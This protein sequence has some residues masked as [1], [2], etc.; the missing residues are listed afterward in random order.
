MKPITI[1]GIILIVLGI[2]VG[3]IVYYENYIKPNSKANE[4]LIEGKLIFERGDKDSVNTAINIFTKVIAK[5][6]KSKAVTDA[7][8]YIGRCYEKL[9]LNRL[10][11]LKYNYIIKNN[12]GNL[13]KEF[14]KEILV[15]LAHINILKQYSEEGINQLF[16][17]LNQSFNRE[18]RSRVY[19][20]LGHTYLKLGEYKRSKR[21]FDISLTENGSNEDAILGK[22]RANKRMGYDNETYDLYDHFLKYYGAISQYTK[23][24][25]RSYKEQAYK[26]G[27]NAFRRG[28]YNN[29]I[30][31]F[32]RVLRNFPYDK[33]S[34]NSLY[35]TGESYFALRK[36]DTSID[37]FNRVLT[38]S[39]YHKDQDAQIKKGY[40]YFM[41]KKFD[42]AA[43][44]F[45][46]YLRNYPSGK[47][48]K[49]AR[50]WK[51]MSTKELLYRIKDKKLPKTKEIPEEE[52]T[53]EEDAQEQDEEV[54]ANY[55]YI[56]MDRG[57]RI[58]LENVAE[59]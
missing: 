50:D 25:R 38:N 42:L 47:Y 52:V 11:Y 54:S 32:K 34:E 3:L 30:S 35:W 21:M 19:S 4:L 14:S 10:A 36:F 1:I 31:F 40:A 7:Y 23:D 37:Y 20:E 58:K 9:G 16:A 41:N 53:P 26:S 18:F 59:L 8:Y 44:E 48:A 56:I 17:I 43:K 13:P 29:A 5:Y 2:G 27:L 55:E 49:L 6:P 12:A 57:K 39:F 15:R 51:E 33:W 45:Q 28:G 22:A 24:V 46:K